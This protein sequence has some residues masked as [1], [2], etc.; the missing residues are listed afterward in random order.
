[1]SFIQRKFTRVKC[2][3][4]TTHAD[5]FS[6]TFDKRGFV[7]ELKAIGWTFCKRGDLCPDCS[8]ADRGAE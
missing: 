6:F 3:N 1:M 7:R 2:D 8:K 4:C 5:F